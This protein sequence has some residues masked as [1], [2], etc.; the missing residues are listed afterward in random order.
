MTQGPTLRDIGELAAI[1]RLTRHLRSR[2]D[3]LCHAGDDCAI[4]GVGGA[5]LLMTSDAVIEGRHFTPGTSP[6]AV[7]R[8]IAGR[9]LSD[10]AA[11]GGEP[12]WGLVNIEATADT[13]AAVVETISRQISETADRFGM[14]IVGGDLSEGPNLQIHGFAVGEAPPGQ[15]VR[16][17]GAEP[18]DLICVT[19]SLGASLASGRHL[20]FEPRI[21]EGQWLRHWATAM[22]DVSDG[23][24][25][26]LRHIMSRSQVGAKIISSRIPLTAEAA[27]ADDGRS[28]LDHALYDGE[29][30]ELLF[31]IPP[32]KQNFVLP[33]WLPVFDIP[34]TVIGM[35]TKQTGV[36]EC[37]DD[38]GEGR[39]ITGS[40]FV[41][42]A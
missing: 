21:K 15:A 3:I 24:A 38:K 20:T 17:S 32:D 23:L 22:I 9:M 34:C 26:D 39:I 40:G 16:R 35:I 28:A 27:I 25:T 33:K 31:T 14:V 19:G 8:K 5:E 1:E 10:I 12:R 11:M 6:D 30:Y 18:G 42:F 13:P 2:R 36:L 37:V 7:G 4:V 41:H 29:D